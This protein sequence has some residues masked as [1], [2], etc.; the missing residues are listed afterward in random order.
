[1]SNPTK[2]PQNREPCLGVDFGR[3]IN[4]GADQPGDQDTVFLHGG[5]DAAMSTPGAFQVFELLPRIVERFSGRAWI[6]SKCGPKTQ[7][8]TLQW[9]VH[10]DFYRR[11]GV[12]RGNVR[13]CRRRSDKAIHCRGLRITHFVDDRLDVHH[14]L[15]GLVPNLYLFG[16]Q[17]APVPGWVHPVRTW[18]AAEA[19]IYP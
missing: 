15:R 2:E 1:M 13:F 17:S 8:R 19:V 9:L 7:E 16:P 18:A 10:H 11:T 3:V 12:P 14:A 5:H 4:G 6:V